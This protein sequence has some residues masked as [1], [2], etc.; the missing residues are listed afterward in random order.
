VASARLH[1]WQRETRAA[2]PLRERG[3]H[4]FTTVSPTHQA[5]GLDTA[6]QTISRLRRARPK[7]HNHYNEVSPCAHVAS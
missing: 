2:A 5:P 1:R 4:V 6:S 3:P 7:T